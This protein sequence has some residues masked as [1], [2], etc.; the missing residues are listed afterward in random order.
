MNSF[1]N[2]RSIPKSKQVALNTLNRTLKNVFVTNYTQTYKNKFQEL[3]PRTYKLLNSY[4][5]TGENFPHLDAYRHY[6]GNERKKIVNQMRKMNIQNIHRASM[7]E[8]LDFF[9]MLFQKGNHL[10]SIQ[11]AEHN[12]NTLMPKRKRSKLVSLLYDFCKNRKLVIYGGVA[13]NMYIDKKFDLYPNSNN[14][15]MENISNIFPDFDIF[16]MNAF[17][18]A[19]TFLNLCKKNGFTH[20]QIKR[21]KHDN[22]WKIYVQHLQIADFTIPDS[23]VPYKIFRGIRYASI[24]F[25]KLGLY[26]SLSDPSGGYFRWLKD[27]KRLEILKHSEDMYKRKHGSIRTLLSK[28]SPFQSMV[29]NYYGPASKGSFKKLGNKKWE[30]KKIE[31]SMKKKYEAK[32]GNKMQIGGKTIKLKEPK[33]IEVLN[34]PKNGRYVPWTNKQA[35]YRLN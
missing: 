33:V 19:K 8:K 17:E 20:L 13:L 10:N 34:M 31:N 3:D 5:K 23:P 1:F 4:I 32:R 7:Y 14:K 6:S 26:K 30:N 24:D 27:I 9:D 22:T 16:S 29:S 25:L 21:A 35:S 11:A 12:L 15:R 2:R 18:D 28:N